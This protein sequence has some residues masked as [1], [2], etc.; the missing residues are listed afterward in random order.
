MK[1][2]WILMVCF[3]LLLAGCRKQID[4]PDPSLENIFGEWQWILTEETT[5]TVTPAT[6]GYN[7]S[8][9]FKKNGVYK[10][11]RDGSQKDRGRYE[12]KSEISINS[13]TYNIIH[14]KH[15]TYSDFTDAPSRVSFM[16]NDTLRLEE[17][18]IEGHT[19]LFVRK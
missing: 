4:L 17:E 19:H 8:F 11:Y 1:E 13:G 18:R 14:F 7:Q 12:I 10:R 9:E 3:I 15:S 6:V 16:G 5:A 2:R